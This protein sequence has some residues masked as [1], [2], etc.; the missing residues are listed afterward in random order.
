[1]NSWLQMRRNVLTCG[2]VGLFAILMTCNP[3]TAAV[4]TWSGLGG[5]NK[6]SNPANWGDGTAAPNFAA[7]TDQVVFG[8]VTS[9][10][11]DNRRSR[12][13]RG[14]GRHLHHRCP[15]RNHFSRWCAG[16]HLHGS[17]G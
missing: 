15:Q 10:A 16:V 7:G 9:G 13:C 14:P 2:L 6:I 3:A 4:F 8:A 17:R 5:D 12:P 1:M 11:L